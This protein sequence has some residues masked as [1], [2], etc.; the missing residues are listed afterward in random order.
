MTLK[1]CITTLAATAACAS[2]FALSGTA[3]AAAATQA[4]PR[5]LLPMATS[6]QSPQRG[7]VLAYPSRTTGA[8]PYLLVT[9]D[10]GRTW[11]SLPAPPVKF[12]ADNDQPDAIW[13]GGVIAV[14]DGTHVVITRDNGRH[15]T[16][17]SAPS[18]YVGKLVVTSGRLYALVTGNSGA[19]VYSGP[20][21]GSALRQV[22][23]LKITGSLTYGDITDVGTLQVDLGSGY[24]AQR[25][26][27][28]RD[29]VRFVSAP[30]PCP[31]TTMADLGGVRSG[32]VI[33]LCN[34]S[35]S[36]VGPG[37]N[38]KQVWIAPRLG[39]AFHASGPVTTSPNTQQF[40]AATVRDMTIAT[41]FDLGVTH[42]A[43]QTWT[44]ELGQNNGAY[45]TD[46]SFSNA[47][48]GT[49]VCNT[50]NNAG[51]VVFTVYRTTDA[52]RTWHALSIP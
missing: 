27:Y 15:W 46:L 24:T 14:T 32:R 18:G 26:W 28:S 30:R 20:I 16:H 44:A 1:R 3:G 34:G 8:I 48:T 31:V 9:G 45:W 51:D 47:T 29:G 33:A 25:Y 11:R 40:A 19:A 38:E 5:G 12:P 41:I 50:V 37:E 2:A 22:P 23:G 43:G 35:P 39:G 21:A 7:I 49:I 36:G 4:V 17:V 6:W 42:N 52:A 10:G 13:S